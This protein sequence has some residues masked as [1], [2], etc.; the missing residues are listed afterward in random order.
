MQNNRSY[1]G[2][3]PLFLPLALV[4]ITGCTASGEQAAEEE[5]LAPV[6]VGEVYTG[7]RREFTVTGEVTAKRRADFTTEFRT[8]VEQVMVKPGDEVRSG[9][10]LVRLDA[11]NVDQRYNTAA[12]SYTTAGLNLQQARLNAQKVVE[13]AEAALKTAETSLRN[14]EAQDAERRK[15]A[16]R[17]LEAAKT[18]VALSVDSAEV[19]LE[20]TIRT[21]ET[22]V[23]AALTTADAMIEG[24]S[25]YSDNSYTNEIH[26]GVKDSVFLFET[27]TRLMANRN[28]LYAFQPSYDGAMAL[29]RQTEQT[30][31]DIIRVLNNSVTSPAYPQSALEGN[32]TTINS[33]LSSVRGLIS[34][35]QSAQ[36][37]VKTAMQANGGKSESILNAEAAYSATIADLDAT[38]ERSRRQVEE[39]KIALQSART[40]AGISELSARTS[41]TSVSGELMQAKIEKDK[42]VVRAP[43]DGQV[44]D[45][46]AREG[47]TMQSGDAIVAVEDTSGMKIVAYLP[48][49]SAR[50]L[51]VNDPVRVG[52]KEQSVISAIAPS[53]DPVTKKY[54]VEIL[55]EN[56]SLKPG[57]FVPVLFTI[58]E[59]E[60]IDP[61]AQRIFVPVT[62]VQLLSTETFV[63]TVA[64][65]SGATVVQKTPVTL[66]SIEGQ[67]VE[68]VSGLTDGDRIVVKG[69][70]VI[71][72]EGTKVRVT[73][74]EL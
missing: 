67:S 3:I 57:E 24:S 51:K 48:A 5:F 68:I 56:S 11:S 38:L 58:G 1:I 20:N 52:S 10:I 44:A 42:L 60:N 63:W 33:Q 27:K 69:G 2:R 66:G 4:L 34:R 28:A 23:E 17:T 50:H 55:L 29:L 7:L 71:E 16:E 31:T 41:L 18:N 49:S 25:L 62:A 8:T 53:A 54:K 13:S 12:A 47:S 36:T 65:G 61:E 72:D 15:Q 32:I 39:A 26:I 73:D 35:L 43:F 9:Q 22:T 70:R 45:V 74:V 14:A 46:S 21:T 30:L 6:D 64:E 40:S 37:A 59:Q 19:E